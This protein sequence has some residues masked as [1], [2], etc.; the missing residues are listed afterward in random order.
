LN[1]VLKASGVAIYSAFNVVICCGLV[2]SIQP[3]WTYYF[4]VVLV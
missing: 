1:G 3:A 2:W 4:Y